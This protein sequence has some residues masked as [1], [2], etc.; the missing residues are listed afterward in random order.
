MG[1]TKWYHEPSSPGRLRKKIRDDTK[2]NLENL[3]ASP[4][5]K[6]RREVLIEGSYVVNYEKRNQE[7][8][9][10]TKMGCFVL[11]ECGSPNRHMSRKCS[12]EK[13]CTVRDTKPGAYSQDISSSLRDS[14]PCR[15]EVGESM[16]EPIKQSSYSFGEMNQQVGSLMKDST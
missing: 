4:A 13:S 11:Q 1:P 10:P 9:S 6:E 5:R 14:K 12:Q 15:Q 7:C 2:T 3:R 16:K 8:G